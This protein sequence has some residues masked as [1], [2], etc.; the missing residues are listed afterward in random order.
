MNKFE[1]LEATFD[2]LNEKV[3]QKQGSGTTSVRDYCNC[4]GFG[5]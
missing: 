5:G 3:A 1:I 2:R 4:T